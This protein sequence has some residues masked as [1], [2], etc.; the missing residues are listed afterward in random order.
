MTDLYQF[1]DTWDNAAALATI[2]P[3]PSSPGILYGDYDI[4]ALRLSVPQGEAYTILTFTSITPTDFAALNTFF[5]V[6]RTT[7]SNRGTFRLR[8][9][10]GSFFNQNGTILYPQN[11]GQMKRNLAFW[12]NVQYYVVGLRDTT[13]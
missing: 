3:Q 13:P 11:P 4:S 6:S 8:D 10:D 7:R 9:D 5:G 1:A 2:T 12:K